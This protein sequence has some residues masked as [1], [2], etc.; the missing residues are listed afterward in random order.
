MKDANTA[1]ILA[2]GQSMR[3]GFDKQFLKIGDQWII[4]RLLEQLKGIFQ[5]IIIVTNKPQSYAN[6]SCNIVKDEIDG[7]GPLGGIHAGLKHAASAFN[8]VI[9]CDMP[10]INTDY[11][12]YMKNLLE[13]C[14]GNV[15]AVITRYG[16]WIE[17]FNSFYGKS[18]IH[19]IEEKVICDDKRIF[20]LL[21][22]VE[23][24][25][26]EEKTARKYSPNWEMFMNLNKQED[27]Q[28]F[29]KVNGHGYDK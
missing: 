23:V 26:I 13:T 7:F 12:L 19:K 4:D 17:P 24:L 6:Y 27:Y 29:L 5:E 22:E 28:Q 20:A 21:K 10:Y 25:Y 2:G 1:I 14:E 8:Y 18:L 3:M 16:E 9:A 11:I 15:E